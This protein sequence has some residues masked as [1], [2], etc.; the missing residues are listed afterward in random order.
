MENGRFFLYPSALI[1]CV[2]PASITT[3][4][5]SCISVCLYDEVHKIG[6]M[7]HYMLPY[8]N[9]EGLSSP[10]YGNIAIKKLIEEM[11]SHGSNQ[12]DLIA[13]VF[14]GANISKYEQNIYAVDERNISV[15]TSLLK[16]FNIPVISSCLGG[17]K[18]R[19][20]K[21]YTDTGKVLHRFI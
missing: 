15:A 19:R 1:V 16:E 12:T 18:G 4:L 17:N 2:E 8:W 5:G 14:G 7:N 9:G 21:Y 10:K 6:G 11:L 13:K 3:I 20:I